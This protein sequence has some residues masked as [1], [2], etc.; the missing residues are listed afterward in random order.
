[1]RVEGTSMC[2]ESQLKHPLLFASLVLEPHLYHSHGKTCLLGQ[3]LSHQSGWFGV[4]VE[5]G[6][7]NFQLFGFDGCSWSPSLPILSFL[8]VILHWESLLPLIFLTSCPSSR[9][10]YGNARRLP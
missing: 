5:A 7:E 4:L 2:H 10:V 6:F 3:L 9:L 8:L 1:M